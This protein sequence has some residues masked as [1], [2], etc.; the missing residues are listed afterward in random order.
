MKKWRGTD[1]FARHCKSVY[2]CFYKTKTDLFIFEIDKLDGI[3]KGKHPTNT[4]YT[5]NV[6][7]IYFRWHPETG[8]ENSCIWECKVFKVV[9]KTSKNKSWFVASFYLKNMIHACMMCIV[10]FIIRCPSCAWNWTL[11]TSSE[12]KTCQSK[13]SPT[14]L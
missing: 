14:S 2:L 10:Y 1:T 7:Q 12:N 4:Q 6:L 11:R 9:I 13:L 3:M 8:C 5:W